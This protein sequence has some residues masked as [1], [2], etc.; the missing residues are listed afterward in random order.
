VLDAYIID[1][2][3]EEQRRID[4]ER[5][6]I[7]IERQSE[8]PDRDEAEDEAPQEEEP[9]EDAVIRIDL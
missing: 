3:K 8:R 9:S 1:A 7:R 4:Q 6:R 2:L 5:P